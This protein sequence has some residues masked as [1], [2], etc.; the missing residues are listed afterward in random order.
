MLVVLEGAKEVNEVKTDSR[1]GRGTR[2]VIV[3]KVGAF[4]IFTGRLEYFGIHQLMGQS[5]KPR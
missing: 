5:A 1:C 2:S 3:S 4:Q